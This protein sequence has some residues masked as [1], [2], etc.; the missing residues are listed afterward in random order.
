VL[1]KNPRIMKSG[2]H[3]K[4]FYVEM[5]HKL[6]RDGKWEGEIWDKRKNGE[7]YPR[8]MTIT[9][10]KDEQ[11]EVIQYVSIFS[12]ITQECRVLVPIPRLLMTAIVVFNPLIRKTI[13]FV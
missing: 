10:I 6:Q 2:R 7:I 12:D 1:G 5:F 4:A 11:Q 13:K 8:W 9:A 3:D